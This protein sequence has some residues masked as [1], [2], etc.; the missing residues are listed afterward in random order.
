MTDSL[1]AL[2]DLTPDLN[3]HI[4]NVHGLGSFGA[5][6]THA[7]HATSQ[8][9]FYAEWRAIDVL[10]VDGYRI[11]RCEIFDEADLDAAL[12]RFEELSHPAP[13][14]ENTASQVAERFMERFAGND[15]DGMATMLAG[16]FSSDDR[17]RVVGAGVRDG[18]DA[19]MT[20]MRAT[21]DLWPTDATLT[22]VA[23][24]G[25]RLVLLRTRFSDREPGDETYLTELFGIVEI[26][27][28]ER[29]S[30][31]ITF[32]LDDFET[33]I[34]ELDARYVAGEAAEHARTWSAISRAYA[35]ITS[36]ELP[37]T[38]ADWVNHDHRRAAAFA[39]GD[40]IEYI[41][42]AWDLTTELNLYVED[43][44]RLTDLGAVVTH[45]SHGTSREGFDA[46]WRA[47]NIFTVEGEQIS[48]TEMFDEADLDT[49]L[50]KFEELKP[51]SNAAGQ[52]GNQSRPTVLDLLRG[53]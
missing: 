39:P 26:N 18:Q 40:A 20:D 28:Y 52:R 15:W 27:A 33:A 43:V 9:G 48:R 1:R 6:V 23:T 19:W 30:A 16:N 32:D 21:A 13:Q 25:R 4:E 17:R 35:S 46:E 3:I 11:I 41:R 45:A 34:A 12:A 37:A 51:P 36:R 44:H 22:V 24:R 8:E 38:T 7:G 49:A 10:M 42:A 31:I 50:A 14:L 5:V 29:I 47:V 2:W 53:P